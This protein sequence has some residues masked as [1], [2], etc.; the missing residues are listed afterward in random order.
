MNTPSETS[1]NLTSGYHDTCW[2]DTTPILLYESLS[3][4]ITADVVIVGGGISGLSVAYTATKAG[5]DV[6]VLEDGNIGSGETG[7]TSAHL[8]NALDDRYS[9]LE[10]MFG[11][12]KSRMAAESHAAAIDMIEQIVMEE[13]ID[14]DFQRVNGYLFPH[15]SDNI[16]TL[17]QELE[18]AR[19]AGIPAELKLKAPG[20]IEA[21]G[22]F[23][24]FPYQAQFHPLKYIQ[25][26]CK[27]ITKGGGRIFTGTHVSK[28]N[29]EGVEAKGFS[30]KARHIVVATNTPVNNVF[31]MHTKQFA[32]RTYII[33]ATIPKGIAEP[34]LWWDTGDQESVWAS[35]PYHYVRVQTYDE[36][37]DLLI[38]G[39]E[40]HKTG[41]SEKEHIS[42][43][44]RYQNLERWAR[45][46]FPFIESIAY[47]WSGQVMEPLDGLGFIG[48]NPGNE[49]I[50][51]VTGDSGNGLTHGTIAGILIN[52]LMQGKA[53]PWEELYNPSRITFDV[54][55]DYMKEV[56]NMTSQY[57]DYLT[58]GDVKSLQDI[59]PD[60]GAIVRMGARKIAVYKSEA[61]EVHAFSA[62]CP[63]MGC[64][65][66][67]NSDEKSFDCPCHG[68]R[69]NAYGLVVNGPST[70]DLKP[71]EVRESMLRE[72]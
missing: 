43:E 13:G 71:I 1:A 45:T 65:V 64:Y 52:D 44:E 33:A 18:A 20:I 15:S 67:W 37:H 7:R 46:Y 35:K 8:S 51:I 38:C 57:L 36:N 14:C 68:S 32:Y 16:K 34:S 28:I 6:V 21:A 48:R 54:A 5:F 12:E 30:V 58:P 9:E 59:G 50:Y 11:G 55:G 60:K 39:G 61:G 47:T 25:G 26:L 49:N 56:G 19:R 22:P 17:D 31:T 23:L 69:F 10:K 63:H 42:E 66:H 29:E 72:K 4:H 62:V 41:Q 40:D 53:N 70:S 24:Q 3:S 2:L 27:A